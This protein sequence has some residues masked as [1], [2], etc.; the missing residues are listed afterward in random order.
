[1]RGRGVFVVVG[2]G[3]LAGGSLAAVPTSAGAAV[4]P[5]TT[6]PA[7][8]GSRYLA[9]GDSVTFGYREPTTVPAP[10][11]VSPGHAA[12]AT[13]SRSAPSGWCR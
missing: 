11:Y 2:I 7:V 8:P 12:L 13:F 9:L 4:R 6:P 5:I 3:L 1:M 10:N